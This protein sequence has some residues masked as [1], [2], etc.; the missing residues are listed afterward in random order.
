MGGKPVN[1]LTWRYLEMMEKNQFV[2]WYLDRNRK[3]QKCQP[4]K[5]ENAMQKQQYKIFD[6]SYHYTIGKDEL[7]HEFGIV[8]QNRKY[9][10]IAENC[11]LPADTYPLRRCTQVND[12]II[13]DV[14][15]GAIIFTQKRFLRE[16]KMCLHCGNMIK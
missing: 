6:G 10:I 7:D 4:K 13:K 2:N 9:I 12:C 1:N 8:T 11:V 14:D 5:G 16:V 3:S 15:C